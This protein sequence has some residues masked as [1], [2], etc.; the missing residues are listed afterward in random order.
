MT[1][2]TTPIEAQP[3][4]PPCGGKL[5]NLVIDAGEADELRE[6]ARSL[7]SIR[8]SARATC[9]LELLATGA[10]SPVDRFMGSADYARVL[11]DMRLADGHLFPVP[12]TLPVD[13]N[14]NLRT[15][16][17]VALCDPKN[18]PLAVMHV[19]EIFEWNPVDYA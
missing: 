16:R 2:S 3:L 19:E 11:Q 12:V 7:P 6:Y 17:D 14:V 4:I 15:G 13:T 1:G 9:D 8:L 18:D 5:K 10:F